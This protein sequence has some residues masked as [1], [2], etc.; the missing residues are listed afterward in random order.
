MNTNNI[1]AFHF[2]NTKNNPTIRNA[3]YGERIISRYSHEEIISSFPFL[4]KMVVTDAETIK[5]K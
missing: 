2:M 5:Y 1:A 3:K 4:G